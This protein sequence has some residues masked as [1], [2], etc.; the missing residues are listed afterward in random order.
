MK[1]NERKGGR[2][3]QSTDRDDG[4][5]KRVVLCGTVGYSVSTIGAYV[6]ACVRSWVYCTYNI[7][8][9]EIACL[10]AIGGD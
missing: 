5:K 9:A 3:E 1:K 10:L 2:K 8:C 4:G 6:R 7:V